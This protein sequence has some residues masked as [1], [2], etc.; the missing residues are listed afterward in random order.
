MMMM[1]CGGAKRRG[2][3]CVRSVAWLAK[4]NFGQ[5][6]VQTIAKA[7]LGMTKDEKEYLDKVA[8]L[9]CCICNSPAEIH[10]VRRYG[11][12]RK[13]TKVIPLCPYHHRTGGRGGSI[14]AGKE[15]WINNF[16]HEDVWLGWV[17]LKLGE[18]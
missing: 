10:H 18:K 16:G 14:H 4:T 5:T 17:D 6:K 15:S 8:E 1:T 12:K 13:H 9:R 7:Y 11:E 3:G 2:N